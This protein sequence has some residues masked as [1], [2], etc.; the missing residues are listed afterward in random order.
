MTRS[1]MMIPFRSLNFVDDVPS[2]HRVEE[3]PKEFFRTMRLAP[4]SPT[5]VDP[6]DI[7]LAQIAAITYRVA[8]RSGAGKA[9]H[10]S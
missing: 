1:T 5:R 4:D 2:L 8:K 7:P 6:N 3:R 9:F 10:R